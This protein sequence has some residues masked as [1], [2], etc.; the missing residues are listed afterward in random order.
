MISQD[1]KRE[2]ESFL[3]A[4]GTGTASM[5]PRS[6]LDGMVSFYCDVRAEDCD[7]VLDGDMLL[8]QWGTYDWGDGPRFEFDITRQLSRSGEDEDIWQL[9][10]TFRFEPTDELRLLGKGD[11]WCH[12]VEGLDEFTEFVRSSGVFARVADRVD[13]KPDLDYECAG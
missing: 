5:T 1:A 12:S 7:I 4:R 2:F 9:H 13:V 8:F 6:G 10:L 11:R 3:A